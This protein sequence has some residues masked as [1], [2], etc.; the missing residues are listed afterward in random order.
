MQ[1]SL[2]VP[3]SKVS[4]SWSAVLLILAITSVSD[5]AFAQKNFNCFSPTMP[6]LDVIGAC[7]QNIAS[8]PVDAQVYQARGAAWQKLGD[9]DR[10]IADYSKSISIDPKYIRAFYNR[11]VAW[12]KR[13]KLDNALADFRY[14]AD[15]DPSFPDVQ[16]AIERVNGAKKKIEAAAIKLPKIENPVVRYPPNPPTKPSVSGLLTPVENGPPA[17]LAVDPATEKRVALVIGNSTYQNISRL[18]NPVNDARLMAQALSGAGFTLVGGGAQIDLDKVRFDSVIQTLGNQIA[19]ADVALFYY[20]GHGVQVRGSN[21]LVPVSANPTKEADVDFQM[22]DVALVLRQMEGAGTK[23]NFIILDACRNNPFGS[24]GLRATGGGL[25]Q[26][27]APEGTL[28][29]YATQPGSVAQ[30]GV[31]GDS[32]Y[33]KALAQALRRPGL[34]VFDFFNEVGLAVKQSTRG[35]QQPWMSSSPINGKF[36]FVA[37]SPSSNTPAV[38]TASPTISE[39]ALAWNATKET[40]NPAVLEAFVKHYGDSFFANLARARLDE[41]KAAVVTSPQ[42]A[43]IPPPG[44]VATPASPKMVGPNPTPQRAVLY[45]EDNTDPKGKQYVGSVIWRTEQ[46]RASGGQNADIAV[47]ADI[48]IPDRKF[49][50]TMSFRRNTDTSL[51]ASHTAE[52]TFILPPDFA[53][54]RVD[55]VAGILMKN[56]EQALGTPLAGLAVKVT[57]SFFLEG[58][59]NIAA[60]R[61]HNLQL[62]KERGWFD[63]PLVYVNQRRAIIAIEKG[64]PGDRAF[65]DA[66]AA[67]GQSPATTSAR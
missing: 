2:A 18:D 20:A 45:E 8:D 14:F 23:L 38:T 35:S 49:K 39:A 43:S 22:V 64:A 66:F 55:N 42:M 28:I 33:T 10:A 37:A 41:L 53:G 15:L 62:L 58:L 50:M 4:I 63:V 21:Y 32:P 1:E 36:Y 24:R 65:A 7:D 46:I 16:R 17:V 51:P 27:N 13:G 3:R 61:T 29:S 54:G 30:D 5:A 60:E 11:G 67:W 52:L 31:D 25:A 9:Y 19:G 40:T 57:D 12:E 6:P 26:M 44:Q 59:S 47:R 34:G 48:E 56:N